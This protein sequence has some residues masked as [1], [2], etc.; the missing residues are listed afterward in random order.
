MFY[1]I[2]ETVKDTFAGGYEAFSDILPSDTPTL[3]AVAVMGAMV[4]CVVISM[5]AG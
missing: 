3:T 4:F 2:A 1:E 5:I